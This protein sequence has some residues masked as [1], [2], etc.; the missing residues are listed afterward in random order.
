VFGNP[1]AQQ[2]NDIAL[3]SYA[4]A[5]LGFF[6]LSGFLLLR[7]DQSVSSLL[8]CVASLVTAAWALVIVLAIRFGGDYGALISPAETLRT[9]AWIAFLVSLL[10]QSWRL[11][12]QITYAFVFS[13]AMGFVFAAQL[14]A[15]LLPMLG[16]GDLSPS[17]NAQVASAML[18]GRLLC[19]IGGLVLVENVYRNAQPGNR[20]GIRLLCIG[21]GGLFAYDVFLFTAPFL[22]QGGGAGLVGARGIIHALI[23]VLI[24]VSAQRNRLLR[25]EIQVSRHV[26]FHSLS[27]IAIGVYLIGMAGAAYGLRFLGGRWGEVLQIGFLFS[28]VLIGVILFFS[29]R[30]RAWMRVKINKHF[31]AFKYDYRSEWLRYINTVSAAPSDARRSGVGPT[32]E[33]R[34][35]QAMCDIVDSPGGVIWLKNDEGAFTPAAR[36]NYRSA[37][38]GIEDAN[39]AFVRYLD[40]R[41]R[42]IDCDELR[43]GEGD[44][45]DVPTP[46]W[47]ANDPQAWLCVPLV[48]LDRLIGF[49]VIEQPRSPRALNW[50]DYDLLRTIGRQAGSYLAEQLSQRALIEAGQFEEFNRRFAFIIHDIKNLVSQLSLIVRNADRHVDNPEFQRDMVLTLKDSVTKMN[51]L[52]ARLQQHNTAQKVNDLVNLPEILGAVVHTKRLGYPLLT[53]NCDADVMSVRGEGGRLEQVFT[54]LIQNAI[55]ASQAD[56]PIRVSACKQ[57]GFVRVDV[58][59]QGCGMSEEFIRSDLFKPFRSTKANGFGI[60]AYEAREIVKSMG[61]RLDVASKPGDGSTFSVTLPLA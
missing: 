5:A 3:A 1:V 39:G 37:V 10:A 15:D 18:L 28:A 26:V 11:Q 53:M 30:V 46:A 35:A 34:A 42:I 60:G 41:G 52:L 50:E 58:T 14:L 45:G 22:F 56:A 51:D 61:G 6:C 23:A 29:G 44:Y 9:A 24:A 48:H 8:L 19:A 13:V 20:W 32:L 7:K 55:D 17:A 33:V 49:Q 21:I 59:D 36:W 12:E 57:E 38:A 16:V 2:L 47:I 27:L 40:D 54:H 25:L 43:R 31:F 4:L